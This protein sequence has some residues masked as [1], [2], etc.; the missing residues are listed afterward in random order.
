MHKAKYKQLVDTEGIYAAA[1]KLRNTNDDINGQFDVLIQKAKSLETDWNS[2]AGSLA[3]SKMYELFKNSE[4]RY[5][6]IQNY[7][8]MLEQQVNPGYESAEEANT[9]LADQFK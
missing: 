5:S 3:C 2:A 7:I 8:N 6:V 9:T 4:I 1:V